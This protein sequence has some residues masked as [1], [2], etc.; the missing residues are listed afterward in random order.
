MVSVHKS[1]GI[2]NN[3]FSQIEEITQQMHYCV[4]AQGTHNALIAKLIYEAGRWFVIGW[5]GA[6]GGIVGGVSRWRRNNIRV[7]QATPGTVSE[8]PTSCTRLCFKVPYALPLD[9]LKTLLIGLH[10]KHKKHLKT[11]ITVYF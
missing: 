7:Q 8:K 11:Y 5:P 3:I 1:R 4:K 10:L 2:S 9:F 6:V